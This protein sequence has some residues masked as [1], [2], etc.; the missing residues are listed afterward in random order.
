[1]RFADTITIGLGVVRDD[2]VHD[3]TSVLEKLPTVRWPLPVHD[4]LIAA[5]PQLRGEMEAA[6]D[7]VQGADQLSQAAQSGAEPVE[8]HRRAGELPRAYR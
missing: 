7:R 1:M 8:G 3:V 5:L 2:R 4:P 6:A